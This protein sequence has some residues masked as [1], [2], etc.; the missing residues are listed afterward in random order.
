M[1]DVINWLL[2]GEPWIEYRTRLDLLNQNE[3]ET[4]VSQARRRMLE[5]PKI[6]SLLKEL[7]AWPGVVLSSHK[8]PSQSYHK[9]S[10][11]ADLGIMNGD[12][13]VNEIAERILEHQSDEGPFTLPMNIPQHFGGSGNDEW[14]WALCDAPIVLY[15]L[16][17]MGYSEDVR[18]RKAIVYLTSLV[19]ETGWPCAVSPKLGKFRGPGRRDDPCPYA[20]LAMLKLLSTLEDWRSSREIRVGSESLLSLW[21]RSMMV[22]PYMFYMGTDFRKIKAPLVWYDILHVLDVLSQF[23]WLRDDPRLQQMIEVVASKS[24]SEGRY[25]PE[26][27]WRAW[28]DWEFGQKKQPSRWVTFLIMR[29]LLR[30]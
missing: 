16:V 23:E 12:P 3:D 29:I 25:T 13:Y 10:F 5:D 19:K 4:D 2:E 1:K 15:S 21:E 8:S 18:V 28:R 22:H 30:A 11:L 27:E 7:R 24:D 20:T 26:S 6:T 17:K 9:L 14:A